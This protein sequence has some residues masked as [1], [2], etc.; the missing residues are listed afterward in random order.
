[1]AHEP[2][3]H[4]Q[5]SWYSAFESAGTEG[6]EQQQR[7]FDRLWRAF[8]GARVLVAVVLAALQLF[9]LFSGIS[10]SILLTGLSGVYLLLTVAVL[11]FWRP[12]QQGRVPTVQW[13]MTIGVDVATFA[14]MQSMQN[15][16]VNY[17]P[18]FA[19]PVLLGAILGPLTLALGTAASVTLVLL[20]D[21]W[22]SSNGLGS[23]DTTRFVQTG[24]AG[25]GLFLVALLAHQLA[26]RLAREEALAASSQAAA[27]AQARVNE[28]IIDNLS[29]GVLVVDLHGVVRNANPAA[30]HMLMGDRYPEGARLL[31]SARN[32]WE[33]LAALVSDTF[34]A[35][36][37]LETE[38]TIEH[39]DRP[40]QRLLART[41]LTASEGRR[42]GL[43][44]LFLEDLREVEARVRTEKLASMGRMSAAV[45][46]EIRNPLTAITQANALLDEEVKE[47]AQ[48][49][50]TG[51]IEQNATRLSRIVDDILNVARVQ[52]SQSAGAAPVV[53]LD[54][55]VRVITGEWN[56]QVQPGQRL[57][58]HT[59][60]PKAQ[61]AFEPEHLRRLLVNLLDNAE[62]HASA[63]PASIRVIT[64]PSGQEHVRLSIWSD[65]PPLEAAVLRHLFEP[66]FSSESRSSGLGL[67]ICRELCQRYG[68]H[69]AYQRTQLD[70][71]EGN[72]F[73]VLLPLA[74]PPARTTRP[75]LQ[76]A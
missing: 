9:L 52:P 45:A 37:P 1:M 5:P 70:Q 31:L 20:L 40:S 65:G 75:P 63:Q 66:F 74:A 55:S 72:E 23:Q 35:G 30:Q 39:D 10:G 4:F 59:H 15:G 21:A 68:A 12:R 50:L 22:M 18:L 57:G 24:L 64:Q 38:T 7:A 60:A 19:L 26:I 17:T 29:I 14:L 36:Q 54:A 44:V 34:A 53:P 27:R 67:F 16:S 25:T 33:H 43:C 8:M 69:I 49:R 11:L 73:Y 62:R 58:V 76:T 48:K 71:R 56:A 3:S 61:V 2:N 41:R 51:M 13:L 47:P 6:R 46:H 42:A 32:G 28:V